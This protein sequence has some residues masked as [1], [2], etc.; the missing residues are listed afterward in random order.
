MVIYCGHVDLR[1]GAVYASIVP[2]VLR[3][4]RCQTIE[5]TSAYIRYCKE[6]LVAYPLST[7][8]S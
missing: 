5:Y 1:E 7:G 2:W 4:A 6:G 8:V 3:T